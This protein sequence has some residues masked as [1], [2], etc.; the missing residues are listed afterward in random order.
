MWIK[1]PAQINSKALNIAWV[2][3]WKN[4]K[5]GKYSPILA[6]M[7][8]NWLRVDKAI[9]FFISDSYIAAIPAI[10]IVNVAKINKILVKFSINDKEL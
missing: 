3:R 1:D 5:L 10:N 6:I 7:I 8:P 4:A 9:I 2:I